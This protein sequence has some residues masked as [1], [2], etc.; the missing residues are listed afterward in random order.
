MRIPLAM[1]GTLTVL[2][3]AGV[4][5]LAISNP[6]VAD[7]T[8]IGGSN[9]K[10]NATFFQLG[11]AVQVGVNLNGAS[12]STSAIDIRKG[13]CKSYAESAKWPLGA[14]QDSRLPN[15]KIEELVGNVLVIHKSSAESSPVVACAE[16]KG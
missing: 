11:Q 13:T 8:P 3:G 9:I 6:L 7:I 15:T 14:T 10:G 12:A 4:P 16:I 1:I 2:L 5:A